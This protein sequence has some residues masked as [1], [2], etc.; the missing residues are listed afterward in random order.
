MEQ[1]GISVLK[2][3]TT[4]QTLRA[5]LDCLWAM[6]CK[7]IKSHTREPTGHLK[8]RRGGVENVNVAGEWN[9]QETKFALSYAM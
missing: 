3:S 7:K 2:A 8:R 1:D 9:A 4:R 5:L 6:L